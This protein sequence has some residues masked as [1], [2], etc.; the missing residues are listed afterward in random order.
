MQRQQSRSELAISKMTAQDRK[1]SETNMSAT[2]ATAAV[3]SEHD[4]DVPSDQTS[5]MSNSSDSNL[6]EY[7]D[8]GIS[9]SLFR[10][11]NFE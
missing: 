9:L 10:H 6:E 2:A 11:F 4:I 1:T 3:A 5:S 7:F 8:T